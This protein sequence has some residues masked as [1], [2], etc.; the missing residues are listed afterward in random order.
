MNIFF[1]EMKMKMRENEAKKYIPGMTNHKIR[2]ERERETG[3]RERDGGERERRG[4]ERDGRERE[5]G[6]RERRERERDGR[7][8]ET[9]ERERRERR[10]RDGRE[11]ERDGRERERE[12]GER[13]RDG[14]DIYKAKKC[15]IIIIYLS[16]RHK[17]T[18]NYNT[19]I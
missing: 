10:E 3:E 2:R 17:I 6:E 9:G 16:K 11:R 7:E 1:S 12:T 18:N 13:E 5:T 19:F 14:R 15:Q 8:R 4:R